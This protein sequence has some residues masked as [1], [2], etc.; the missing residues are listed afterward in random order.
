MNFFERKERYKSGQNPLPTM[1]QAKQHQIN[2]GQSGRDINYEK[3]KEPQTPPIPLSKRITI[4][5]TT[6]GKTTNP[7]RLILE[8]RM[9][10]SEQIKFSINKI[11]PKLDYYEVD[12]L[13]SLLLRF[14]TRIKDDAK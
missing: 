6:F 4:D 10:K 7:Q 8:S 13:Y 2:I 12:E 3:P 11:L 9:L 14:A 1:E 5:G